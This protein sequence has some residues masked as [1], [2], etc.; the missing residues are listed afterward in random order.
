MGFGLVALDASNA[1]ALSPPWF[2]FAAEAKATLGFDACVTVD[3]LTGSGNSFQL[4]IHVC[5]DTRADALVSLLGGSRSFGA[6]T[7]SIQIFNAEG[8]Q[9]TDAALPTN[10][11]QLAHLIVVGLSGN[12]YFL[13]VISGNPVHSRFVLFTKSVVQF[14]ADNLAD[15]FGNIN[16]V[17]ADAFDDIFGFSHSQQF[18][19]FGVATSQDVSSACTIKGSF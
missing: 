3:D 7:V 19:G 4:K 14:Q 6:V 11:D 8:T 1:L 15:A 17:A 5:D 9:V 10:P 12:C 16:R 13:D 2:L 18:L